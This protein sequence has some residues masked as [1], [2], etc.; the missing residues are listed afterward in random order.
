MITYGQFTSHS[1][2]ILP[3]K[4]DCNDFTD[5]DITALAKIIADKIDFSDVH[6]IPTGGMRLAN[7]LAPYRRKGAHP[8]LIVDDVFT[9][10]TSMEEA[11][12]EF[13]YGKAI[14]PRGVVIYARGQTPKWI[15]PMFVV[16][17][18]TQS[19]EGAE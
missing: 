5:A 1:G 7:A 8:F 12:V 6:G 4:I 9:V 14:Q 11:R 19:S 2:L 17:E 3:W 13:T 16:Q 10:G 18:W 15:W